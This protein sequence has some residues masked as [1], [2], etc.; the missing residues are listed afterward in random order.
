[1]PTI[2]HT[3]DNNYKSRIKLSIKTQTCRVNISIDVEVIEL[4]KMLKLSFPDPGDTCRQDT[5]RV[6]MLQADW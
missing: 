6:R 2:S 4:Q 3:S 5:P 1:M